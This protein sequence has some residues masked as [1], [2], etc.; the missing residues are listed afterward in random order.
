MTPAVLVELVQWPDLTAITAHLAICQR[1]L[2]NAHEE[3]GSNFGDLPIQPSNAKP[4]IINR[5]RILNRVANQINDIHRIAAMVR[6][7]HQ[8]VDPDLVVRNAPAVK[9]MPQG[10][11]DFLAFGAAFASQGNMP[12]MAQGV[13]VV[14][15]RRVGKRHRNSGK[16][17]AFDRLGGIPSDIV[18]Q[19]L[20][21]RSAGSHRKLLAMTRMSKVGHFLDWQRRVGTRPKPLA[22]QVALFRASPAVALRCRRAVDLCSASFT[23]DRP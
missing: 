23:L 9:R 18:D 6:F 17:V 8:D 19:Q 3:L 2:A 21:R 15:G 5:Y 22:E 12:R 7:L 20:I 4:T 10:Q 16:P 14:L 1:V 11:C 13:E